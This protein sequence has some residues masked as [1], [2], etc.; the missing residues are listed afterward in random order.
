MSAFRPEAESEY[1]RGGEPLQG[2]KGP[3]KG[4]SRTVAVGVLT[5]GLAGA[6]LLLAA[7]FTPLLQVHSSPHL[8]PIATVNTGSHDSYALIPIGLLTAALALVIWRTRN[9][10][11]VLA[12]G[13]LGLVALLIALIGDLPDARA[14]GLVGNSSTNFAI[15]TARPGLG[16]Y[17]ETLGAVVLI[18]TAVAGLLLL[19][20]PERRRA[21]SLR[22]AAS[23]G[24]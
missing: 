11:A 9:R 18:I 19:A 23:A 4:P 15:A 12:T 22:P 6:L 5:G 24:E 21:R 13:V 7:E 2:P 10:L 1:S 20:A 14:T 3:R 16:F 8:T 17:L